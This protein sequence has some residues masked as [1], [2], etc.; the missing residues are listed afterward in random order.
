MI[1]GSSDSSI[2]IAQKGLLTVENL[3]DLSLSELDSLAVELEK[4]YKMSG[5]KSFITPKSKKDKE[6]KLRFDLVLDILNTKVEENEI[7]REEFET[8]SENQKILEIIKRKQDS[9]LESK[10]IEDLKKM[11]K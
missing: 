5:K 9:E 1:A 7:A 10:S 11:L 3:W 4:A 8:E 2:I 6:M